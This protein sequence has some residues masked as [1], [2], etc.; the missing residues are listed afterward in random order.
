ME[1]NSQKL[2]CIYIR[3]VYILG[4]ITKNQ[5]GNNGLFK[6]CVMKMEILW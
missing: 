6:N 5:W 2:S 4:I 1:K 3:F